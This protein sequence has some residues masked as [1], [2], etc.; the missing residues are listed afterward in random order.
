MAHKKLRL[1]KETAIIIME[2]LGKL[3]DCIQFVDL[4]IHNY[5]A[6]KNFGPQ[7]ERCDNALRNIQMF[8]NMADLYKEKIIK[9]TTYESFKTDLENN[10]EKL[11]RRLNTYFDFVENEVDEN[12][13]KLKDLINSY[14]SIDAELSLL[15]EKKSVFDKSSE[16]I[17]SQLNT[18]KI[19]KK[20]KFR[21]GDWGRAPNP[22][23]FKP[24]AECK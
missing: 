3:D 12:N 5:E 16:L 11:D 19:Q 20:T 21:N 15:L 1:P 4:N 18:Y 6:K 7:I 22:K 9:Y 8:E 10:M 14:K 17:F 2:E 13:K 23:Y 24:K